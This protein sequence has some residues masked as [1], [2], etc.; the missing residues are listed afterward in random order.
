MKK[1]TARWIE[2]LQAMLQLKDMEIERLNAVITS[3]A[4]ELG[5]TKGRMAAAESETK[6]LRTMWENNEKS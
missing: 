2:S 6:Y 3:N 5:T 4:E 1:Q